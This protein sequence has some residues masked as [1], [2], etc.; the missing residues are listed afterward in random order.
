M[1]EEP[2]SIDEK[3]KGSD[4]EIDAQ[5]FLNVKNNSMLLLAN[6]RECCI[7]LKER[8]SV[9]R[10]VIEYNYIWNHSIWNELHITI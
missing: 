5:F 3:F 9:R 6:D 10:L 4:Y 7:R 8:R 2:C 1:I